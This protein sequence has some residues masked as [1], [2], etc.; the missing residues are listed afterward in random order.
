MKMKLKTAIGGA[1]ALSVAAGMM[2]AGATNASAVAPSYQPDPDSSGT[3]AFYNAAGVQIT[4]GSIHDPSFATYFAASSAVTGSGPHSAA[5][6]YVTPVD[7]TIPKLWGTTEQQSSSQL[8]GSTVDPSGTINY[9]AN[10]AALSASVPVVFDDSGADMQLHITDFPSASTLNPNVYQVRIATNPGTQYWSSDILVNP[11]SGAWT[12]VYPT[13]KVSTSFSTITANPVSPA[14]HASSVTLSST[15]S[16]GDGTHPAGTVTLLDGATT[17]P[18][19]TLNAATGDV[20]ATIT[21]ADGAHNYTFAFVPTDAT[22]YNGVTSA[23]L[24]YSVDAP[25][26]A[27]ATTT[28]LTGTTTGTVATAQSITAAV[29]KTVGGATVSAGAVQFKIDGA[30]SGAPIAL[31]AG[32]ATFAYTPTDTVAHTI[33]GTFIPA[34][35]ANFQAS[36]DNTGVTV[37]AAPPAYPVDPQTITTTVPAGTL[38]IST[39]YTPLHPFDLGTLVLSADG[40]KYD[41][42]PANFGDPAAAAATDPGQ[43]TASNTP[44]TNN[45]VTI[46][47]TRAG[48]TGWKASAIVTDFTD[49]ASHS[50]AGDGLSFTNITPKFLTGNTL[51]ATNVT[52]A[53]VAGITAFHSAAKQFAQAT[54]G[55]GTVNVTGKLSLTAPSST[56]AGAYT[57]TLTFSIV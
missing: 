45:G 23:A 28:V 15:L 9:P 12:Q 55:P 24:A 16:A 56:I 41:S 21:P 49:G 19:A 29:T 35:P 5:S 11:A 53:G 6:I 47:D 4:S 46:T 40:T 48:S 30:N 50:I 31:V 8:V 54:A 26:P 14:P 18:G 22:T 37:T 44:S 36:S 2:L 42:V 1:A 52:T 33:T 10:I 57:A 17:V 25:A 13:V 32:V 38:V 43:F 39:P 34:N 51:N 3:V 20:S 27:A 7:G